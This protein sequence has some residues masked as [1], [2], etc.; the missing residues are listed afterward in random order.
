MM[1]DNDDKTKG[2]PSIKQGILDNDP[3][4]DSEEIKTETHLTSNQYSSDDSEESVEKKDETRRNSS[5]P[6]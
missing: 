2:M 6:N 5:Q 4:E 3:N 1:K